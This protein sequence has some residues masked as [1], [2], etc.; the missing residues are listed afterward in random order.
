M[1]ERCVGE[2]REMHGGMYRRHTGDARKRHG[3]GLCRRC[4][5][6]PQGVRGRCSGDAREG[7]ALKRAKVRGAGVCAGSVSFGGE[8]CD[9][10]VNV[11]RGR[12]RLSS[13]G[14]LDRCGLLWV[15]CRIVSSLPLVLTTICQVSVFF[16]WEGHP[17]KAN[18]TGRKS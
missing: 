3:G 9:A 15:G 8:E 17:R 6:N 18:Q 5:G 1:H 11:G 14:R 10:K 4:S 2:A 7:D 16:P 13:S 12:Q